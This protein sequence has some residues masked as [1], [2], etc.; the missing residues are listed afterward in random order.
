MHPRLAFHTGKLKNVWL[1]FQKVVREMN[2]RKLILTE[3][4]C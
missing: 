2:L 4:V 1:S 3:N